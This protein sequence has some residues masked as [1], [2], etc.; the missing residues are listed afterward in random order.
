MCVPTNTKSH[1][2]LI[3][4]M[5]T[6]RIN[7]CLTTTLH[8]CYKPS[9]DVS[10]DSVP[11]LDQRLLRLDQVGWS[12]GS[13]VQTPPQLIPRMLDGIEVRGTRWPIHSL[14]SSLLHSVSHNDCSVWTGIVIHKCEI[15]PISSKE[16]HGIWIYDLINISLTS[17]GPFDY[18]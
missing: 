14:N 10:R 13:I 16:W 8:T 1:S 6:S 5:T 12:I 9:N 17:Q 15:G 18:H 7:N 11:L 2:T 3:T 4:C